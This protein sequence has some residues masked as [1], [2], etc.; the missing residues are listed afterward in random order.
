MANPRT[1]R[2]IEITVVPHFLAGHPIDVASQSLQ[3][4]KAL[5]DV[6]ESYNVDGDADAHLVPLD[7]PTQ[8]LLATMIGDHVSAAQEALCHLTAEEA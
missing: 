8:Y 3:R 2:S 6:L 7:A 1:A 5:S 4:A